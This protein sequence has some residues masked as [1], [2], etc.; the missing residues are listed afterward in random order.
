MEIGG[1]RVFAKLSKNDSVASWDWDWDCVCGG[2]ISGGIW[3]CV[4]CSIG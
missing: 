4:D 1:S 2:G 3:G